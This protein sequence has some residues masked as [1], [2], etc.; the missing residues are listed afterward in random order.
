MGW[1]PETEPSRFSTPCCA[2]VPELLVISSSKIY[3]VDPLGRTPL[4]KFLQA[5]LFSTV[6][7]GFLFGD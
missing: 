7:G 4:G 2:L 5:D 1:R 3:P 6:L